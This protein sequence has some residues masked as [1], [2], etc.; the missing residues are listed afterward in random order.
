MILIETAQ[1]SLVACGLAGVAVFGL[2]L[3]GL[4]NGLPQRPCIDVA[5][6]RSTWGHENPEWAVI[7]FWML[8]NALS[9]LAFGTMH[10]TLARPSVRE[11]LKESLP[12]PGLYRP[13]YV[14]VSGLHLAFVAYLWRPVCRDVLILPLPVSIEPYRWLLDV[15]L[16]GGAGS[17]II[18]IILMHNGAQF[19]GLVDSSATAGSPSREL[20]T[21]GM[22][23]LVRHPMYTFT[24]ISFVIG[25][26]LSL[27]RVALA[28]GILGYLYGFGIDLEEASLVEE[29]GQQYLDYRRTTPAVVPGPL[30]GWV[31]AVLGPISPAAATGAREE[32]RLKRAPRPARA[33]T[34]TVHDGLP[35]QV[36]HDTAETEEQLRGPRD[37]TRS[38]PRT[39]SGRH[40]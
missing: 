5:N 23:Q 20:Q 39:S 9:A 38:R 30:E 3:V 37:G 25:T 36:G 8:L 40:H 28:M 26:K 15:A 7:L 4:P 16:A 31:W 13:L 35:S 29:F 24:L 2:W 34:G 10:S 21:T 6:F 27:D 33:G 12:A 32:P 22:Y 19:L 18:V 11:A 14:A 1:W 17:G